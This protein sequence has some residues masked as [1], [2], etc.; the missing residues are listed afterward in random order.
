MLRFVIVMLALFLAG[1]VPCSD[2][3]LTAPGASG[4]DSALSGTWFWSEEGETGFLHIGTTRESN[5]LRVL[6]IDIKDDGKLNRM[7]FAGHSS[8]LQGQRYLNLMPLNS[9]S[10]CNGYWFVKYDF[11]GENLALYVMAVA[12]MEGAVKS[13]E[14]PGVVNDDGG[15]ASI[16]ITASQ[17]ELQAFVLNH[18]LLLFPERK[19]VYRLRL[20]EHVTRPGKS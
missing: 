17:K 19:V 13:G 4:G 9:E 12:V 7:E 16:R 10:E 2:N 5:L 15:S 18:D 1:C 8:L 11:E 6:M 14:L 3:P 20:P